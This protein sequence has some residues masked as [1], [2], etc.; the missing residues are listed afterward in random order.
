M[1]E[2][3]PF[4]TI[5][6]K[7]TKCFFFF[8]EGKWANQAY[9]SEYANGTSIIDPEKMKGNVDLRGIRTRNVKI[10][11]IGNTAKHLAQCA[12]IS[13]T[14]P[15][16]PTRRYTYSGKNKGRQGDRVSG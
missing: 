7:R 4:V 9:R 11:E 13:F 2:C 6:D 5:L 14:F 10:Q 12:K 16:L 1:C 3:I 8:R 15:V